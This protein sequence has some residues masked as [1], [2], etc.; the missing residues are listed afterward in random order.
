M[1]PKEQRLYI[2]LLHAKE[3]DFYSRNPD[4]LLHIVSALPPQTTDVIID[5]IQKIPTLL[6]IVHDL[7]ETTDRRF[8]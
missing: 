3:E 5:E 2:N 6:D 7:I 4:E 8:I 1:V